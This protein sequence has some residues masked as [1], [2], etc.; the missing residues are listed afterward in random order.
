MEFLGDLTKW[1]IIGILAAALIAMLIPD[2]FFTTHVRSDFLG[3]IMAFALSIPTYVCA[4]ASVPIAA[5][6][7]SKGLSPGAAL[8]FLMAGPATNA[9]TIT[10]LGKTLGRRALFAYL[11]SIILSAMMFGLLIDNFLPRELFTAHL[12]HLGAMGHADH[13][14]LPL[15]FK[16]AASITLVA[17]MIHAYFRKKLAVIAA[18]KAEASPTKGVEAQMDHPAKVRIRISGMTCQHCKKT[19]E[20]GLLDLEGIHT[21]RVDL[22]RGEAAIAG[23]TIHLDEISG[24]LDALGY[25]YGGCI[26]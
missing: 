1:F 15:W 14:M 20:D 25:G 13:E 2:D 7:M 16:Q 11:G 19:V 3:M 9:A 24:K 26:K 8:V 17:L 23:E 10:V 6:L 21:V 12:P 5:V 22:E 4:S 18:H